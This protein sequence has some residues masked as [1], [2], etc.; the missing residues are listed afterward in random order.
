M[1][2]PAGSD[3]CHCLAARRNARYL[4]RLYDSH[5]SPLG[6][7][8]SQFSIL[9]VVEEYPAIPVAELADH[10]VMERTTLVR[11]LRPLQAKGYLHSEPSGPKSAIHL[12]LSSSGAAVHEA[13]V[14]LWKDAQKQFEKM[15][16]RERAVTLRNTILGL[17]FGA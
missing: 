15:A 14:C 12:S 11:A 13:A 1:K 10:M 7:S 8:I 6:L 9:A 2:N 4:T 5:L 3:L 17:P 16:G